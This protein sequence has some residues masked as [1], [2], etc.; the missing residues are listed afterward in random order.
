MI[1]FGDQEGP[2]LFVVL[3]ICS[4]TRGWTQLLRIA[5]VC[6]CLR[7]RPQRLRFARDSSLYC[8]NERD[9]SAV[10]NAVVDSSVVASSTASA[11]SAFAA[12]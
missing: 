3:T 7:L 2:S 8:R 10:A 6:S 12:G 11:A 1:S 9:A 4:K 5:F